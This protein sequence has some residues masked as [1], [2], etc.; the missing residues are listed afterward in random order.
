MAHYHWQIVAQ[1]FLFLGG[2]EGP[3]VSRKSFQG[4]ETRT[5]LGKWMT[6]LYMHVHAARGAK[7]GV[8]MG[9]KCLTCHVTGNQTELPANN[10]EAAASL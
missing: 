4:R 2:G 3:P 8:D 9:Q 7:R 1:C 5:G 10:D 6:C